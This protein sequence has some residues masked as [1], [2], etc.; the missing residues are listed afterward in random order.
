MPWRG[1][2]QFGHSHFAKKFK[3]DLTCPLLFFEQGFSDCG[4]AA[5]LAE[6]LCLS[7]RAF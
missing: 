2:G 3:E 1:P 7:V 5:L 6:R 4:F